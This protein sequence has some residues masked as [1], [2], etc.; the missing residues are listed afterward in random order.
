MVVAD[1]NQVL[2]E[3]MIP[4]QDSITIKKDAN[5]NFLDSTL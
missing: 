5:I 1:P 3:I 2:V 4:V